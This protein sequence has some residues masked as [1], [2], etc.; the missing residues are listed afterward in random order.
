MQVTEAPSPVLSPRRPPPGLKNER[1]SAG[2]P[3]VPAPGE[4]CFPPATLAVVC[5]EGAGARADAAP[6]MVWREF[7]GL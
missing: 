3:G 2:P 6:E 5:T 1:R 7:A 4:A